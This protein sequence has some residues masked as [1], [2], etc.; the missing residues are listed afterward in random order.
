MPDTAGREMQVSDFVP[1]SAFGFD[2][3]VPAPVEVLGFPAGSRVASQEQIVA[4]FEA[5][6]ARPTG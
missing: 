1:S 4:W 5:L 6:A 2:P 3:D